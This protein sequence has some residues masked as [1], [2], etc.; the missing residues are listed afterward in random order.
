M[1]GGK[2]SWGWGWEVR[3]L[4]VDEGCYWEV[5]VRMGREVRVENVCEGGEGSFGCGSEG[6]KCEG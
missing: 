2:R 1:R 4:N 3:V 5:R 6:C